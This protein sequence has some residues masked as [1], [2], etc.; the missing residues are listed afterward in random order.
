MASWARS[1]VRTPVS[2]RTAPE[3]RS[4]STLLIND[5]RIQISPDVDLTMLMQ[6]IARTALRGGGFVR[7]IGLHGHEFDIRITPTTQIILRYDAEVVDGPEIDEP[8][9]TEVDLEY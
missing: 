2:D 4:I 9:A 3:G 8:W 5:Q 7:V 6:N 1:P